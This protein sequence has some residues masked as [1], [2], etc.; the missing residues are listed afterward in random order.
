MSGFLASWLGRKRSMIFVNIPHIVGWIILYAAKNVDQIFM[1][2]ILLGMGNGLMESPV[3][4][5]VGEIA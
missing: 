3:I 2:N 4:L 1:G 5:Y